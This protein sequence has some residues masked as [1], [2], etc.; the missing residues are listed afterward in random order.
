M[1][2]HF[3]TANWMIPREALARDADA[4]E[5]LRRATPRGRRGRSSGPP[6]SSSSGEYLP[7]DAARDADGGC[8][9][10]LE[11]GH[12]LFGKRAPEWVPEY[13]NMTTATPAAIINGTSLESP[14]MPNKWALYD[15]A[16]RRG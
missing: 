2:R 16:R 10:W 1:A 7:C 9:T 3:L 11:F 8:A 4:G 15:C 13:L 14:D 5:S 12:E 6:L